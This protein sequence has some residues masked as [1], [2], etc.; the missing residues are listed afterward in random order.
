MSCS[1]CLDEGEMLFTLITHKEDGVPNAVNQFCSF[2]CL[3]HSNLD[4]LID[5]MENLNEY[6]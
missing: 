4:H 2:K 1:Y 3:L 6:R 5:K